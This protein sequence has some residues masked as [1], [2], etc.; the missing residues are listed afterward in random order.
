M[1]CSHHP[2]AQVLSAPFGIPATSPRATW[3]LMAGGSREISTFKLLN[4]QPQLLPLT[5]ELGAW[6]RAV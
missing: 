2:R 1:S 4:T 3:G 5:P 6:G